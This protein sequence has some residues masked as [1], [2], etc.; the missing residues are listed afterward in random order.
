MRVAFLAGVATVLYEFATSGLRIEVG[1]TVLKVWAGAKKSRGDR[2]Q[3]FAS[4][5]RVLKVF[6]A[7]EDRWKSSTTFPKW[8]MARLQLEIFVK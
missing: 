7:L 8:K 2:D 6:E 1:I 3:A 5:R 4:N